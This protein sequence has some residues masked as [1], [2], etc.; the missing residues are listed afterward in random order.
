MAFTF[1]IF[2]QE[3]SF[4]FSLKKNTITKPLIKSLISFERLLLN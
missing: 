1:N 2:F 4:A 3:D